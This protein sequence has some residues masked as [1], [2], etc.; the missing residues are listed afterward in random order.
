MFIDLENPKC[1]GLPCQTRRLKWLNSGLVETIVPLRLKNPAACSRILTEHLVM[2]FILIFLSLTLEPCSC[3]YCWSSQ[4]AIDPFPTKVLLLSFPDI[5]L[6]LW[7]KKC[8]MALSLS[9]SA[10]KCLPTE[11]K[12]TRPALFPLYTAVRQNT[13]TSAEPLSKTNMELPLSPHTNRCNRGSTRRYVH[14]TGSQTN[15]KGKPANPF[16]KQHRSIQKYTKSHL[17]LRTC[18]YNYLIQRY[19]I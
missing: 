15:W 14:L 5:E 9:L 4:G 18:L 10:S 8:K 16:Q 3:D 1:K 11:V 6:I 19:R 7:P 17:H 12:K 2:A 13:Y